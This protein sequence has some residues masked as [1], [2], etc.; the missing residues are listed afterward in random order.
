MPLGGYSS[1]R[2]LLECEKRADFLLQAAS[3]AKNTEHLDTAQSESDAPKLEEAGDEE[4]DSR[5]EY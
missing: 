1:D 2:W 5:A 4:S 3:K